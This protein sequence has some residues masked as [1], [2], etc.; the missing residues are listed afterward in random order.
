MDRINRNANIPNIE[1]FLYTELS[2]DLSNI[3]NGF[4][5][6]VLKEG[7]DDSIVMIDVAGDIDYD[8]TPIKVDVYIWLCAKNNGYKNSALLKEM[9]SKLD[10]I[11]E[12]FQDEQ[13]IYLL[14][15]KRAKAMYINDAEYSCNMITIRVTVL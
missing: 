15:K 12:K 4:F 11:V 7:K 1:D 8:R 6:K 9:E 2:K 10:N 5:P 3:K 13:N 14:N